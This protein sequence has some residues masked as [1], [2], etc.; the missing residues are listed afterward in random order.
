MSRSMDLSC[1]VD[2]RP[3]NVTHFCEYSGRA[4]YLSTTGCTIRTT[5]RPEPGTTLELRLYVPGSAWPIRVSRATVA[6]AHWDEFTVEFVQVP[7]RDHD[8]L[9]YCLANVSAHA[10][11]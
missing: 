1:R 6:W 7:F 10:A 4:E 11:A 2:F 3:V 8:Q 5:D 9:R